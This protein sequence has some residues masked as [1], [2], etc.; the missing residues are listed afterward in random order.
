MTGDAMG[1]FACFLLVISASG[2]MGA[3]DDE[4]KVPAYTLPDP[5][6]GASGNRVTD[7]E[8]W[9]EWRRAEVLELFRSEVYGRSPGRPGK[10]T[11]KVVREDR[12]ALG[13]LGTR[14]DVRVSFTGEAD[15]PG[16]GIA[17]YVPNGAKG[18]VP[19][20]VGI[21]V[22]DTKA[23]HPIPGGA[24]AE[25]LG[26]NKE[27][28]ASTTALEKTLVADLPGK[29]LA[30]AILKRGYGFSTIDPEDVAP[31]DKDRFMDGVIGH[32]LRGKTERRA[33]T[34]GAIGAWAWSLSRALDYFETDPDVDGKRVIVMGHSRRGKTALWAG[35][36]DE[37]FAMVISNNSGCGGAALSRRRFG[38][39]VERINRVFPHWFCENFRK[40]N[41]NEDALP[42]DQHMLV[43]LSAPRPV[44]VASAEQDQWADPKGEFLAAVHAGPV[45][46]LFDK[47]GVGGQSMPAVNQPV[48]ESI[49]YHLRSGK[50]ALSD[51]DWMRYLDF[52]DR[53]LRGE[54]AE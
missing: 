22:F 13:G 26:E 24:L 2:A 18:P 44:Y 37:R 11:F 16:M 34:W 43:A 15:G 48:G 42:V 3:N 21:H 51:Y 9:Q 33:E 10:M 25:N 45:Y 6:V 14:K 1:R 27:K 28:D 35:A 46:G 36:Q 30:A 41:D 40:Y 50:H 31:D 7:A 49:G 5:L 32:Y 17:V 54:V 39:T 38:E 47:G 12:A 19:M 52:A 8:A 53:H 23:S 4:S 29:D 20:F